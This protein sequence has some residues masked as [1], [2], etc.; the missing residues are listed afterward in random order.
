MAKWVLERGYADQLW[1]VVSP[2]NPLKDSSLLIDEKSRL[3]MVKIAI[4]QSGLSREAE[5][6]DVEFLMPKPSYTINTIDYLK[7]KFPDREFILLIGADIVNQ[8]SLWHRYEDLLSTVKILVYPR[9]GYNACDFLNRVEILPTLQM[10]DFSSTQIRDA[11]LNGESTDGM[12]CKGVREY[13]L[14]YRLW[15]RISTLQSL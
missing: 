7:Q 4:E 6:C 15:S 11:L 3:E 9:N 14:K 12:I 2:H 1:F 8:L 10:Y 13:I 5:A